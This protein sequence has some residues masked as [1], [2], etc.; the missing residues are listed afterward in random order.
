MNINVQEQEKRNRHKEKEKLVIA[1]TCK[2]LISKG[3]TFKLQDDKQFNIDEL[4]ALHIQLFEK[5]NGNY[6]GNIN[7]EEIILN[8]VGM[9]HQNGWIS[10]KPSNGFMYVITGYSDNLCNYMYA[11]QSFIHHIA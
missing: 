4:L 11:I 6:N 7:G 9:N 8:F 2:Y 3:F 5:N 1:T 10:F